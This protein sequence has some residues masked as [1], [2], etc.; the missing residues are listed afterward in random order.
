[1]TDDVLE[2]AQDVDEA[3]VERLEELAEEHLVLACARFDV[4]EPPARGPHEFA[5]ILDRVHFFDLETGTA[6][7]DEICGYDKPGR[8]SRRLLCRRPLRYSNS[9]T[10]SNERSETVGPL[11]RTFATMRS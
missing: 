3:A 4:S 2:I 9:N 6:I 8:P 7:G 11:G 5:V 10:D 1:M